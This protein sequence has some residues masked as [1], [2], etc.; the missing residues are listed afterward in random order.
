MNKFWKYIAACAAVIALGSLT[1]CDNDQETSSPNS[2]DYN[3]NYAYFSEPT[4]DYS[5]IQFKANGEFISSLDEPLKLVPARVTKPAPANL[6]LAVTI[7]ENA[8]AEYNSAN[9]TDYELMRGAT[10]VN[11]TMHIAKGEY[12]T[13]DSITVSLADHSQLVN[14][15][16]NLIL[17]IVIT[18]VAGGNVQISKK[19]RL[20]LIFNYKA[21]FI[22][23]Y[24]GGIEL[25]TDQSAWADRLANLSFDY[26]AVASW[27]A[28]E[29][30]TLNVEIDNNLIDQYNADNGTEY[31][32][33]DGA[34]LKSS[35][36]T[37]LT[38]KNM[39]GIQLNAGSTDK[40]LSNG[41]LVPVR[42]TAVSGGGAEINAK[43]AIAYLTVCG[44]QPKVTYGVP[45]GSPI[46]YTDIMDVTVNGTNSVT[47]D[48][49]TWY[50]SDM[51]SN[52][53]SA[54]V[55][56]WNPGDEVIIDLGQE[57]TVTG[58]TT[59]FYAWYYGVK[60]YTAVYTS[61]DGVAWKNWRSCTLG[62]YGTAPFKFSYPISCRYIKMIVG[63][64][65]YS[66]SYGTFPTGFY[67]FE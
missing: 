42:L 60:S 41:Y 25:G 33:W 17:P 67:V 27:A 35:T 58:V 53:G 12:I 49:G 45:T 30:I 37:M 6:T 23:I 31:L 54:S 40:M 48:D 8:V 28:D 64:P 4:N 46:A 55:D 34:S 7:D 43:S 22:S 26:F 10:L 3:I 19:S 11:P 66:S 52:P 61:T 62:Q 24:D 65:S 39:A 38:G 21:N 15:P 2:P 1:S 51:L 9:G 13:P 5:D 63:D 47:D 14:N 16:K 50:W 29:D 18:E 20:F 32:P 59:T 57:K 44:V 56:Y 36:L